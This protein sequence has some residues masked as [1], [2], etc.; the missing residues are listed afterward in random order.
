MKR[1]VV[2]AA[3]LLCLSLA[4]GEGRPARKYTVALV[5]QNHAIRGARIPMMALQDAL[6]A[7]LSG[8]G[9]QVI[10]PYNAIGR[11]LNRTAR[12]ETMPQTSAYDLARRLGAQGA[13][14]ASVI[15]FLDTKIGSNP[16]VAHEYVVRVAFS[17]ADAQTGA[18]VCG[19]MVKAESPQY[20]EAEVSVKSNKL[21]YLSDLLYDAAEKCA[22]ELEAKVSESDWE[23]TPP[24][25]V[26]TP[27]PPPPKG[28]IFDRLVDKLSGEMLLSPQ[29]VKNYEAQRENGERLP[30]AVIGGMENASGH[31]E[32]DA[33]LKIAGERFRKKLFDSK[34]FDIKDDAVLV[35]LAKR[36]VDSGNSATEDGDLMSELKQHGSPDFFVVGNLTLFADLDG[37]G[38]YKFRVSIHSLRT[39]KIVWEGIETIE[40]GK[41][42]K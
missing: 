4:F 42:A 11:D 14:T 24:P 35:S 17:L 9:F 36:I 16:V 8:R 21:E 1:L 15:E 13:L 34:L 2:V 39:G 41:E 37:T 20:T 30:I 26:R 6:T 10:N 32:F 25:P 38:Y 33:G 5:V 27:S 7:R 22:A 19:S 3:A 29:F 23:P 18:T 12:G 28:P 40:N 31:P